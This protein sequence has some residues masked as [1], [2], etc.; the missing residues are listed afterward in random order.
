MGRTLFLYIFK[1]LAK[2]FILAAVALAAI[3]SFGG[4]LRPLT[5]Q[6]LDV[7]QMGWMLTFLMPAMATYSLPIAA[8][9]ACTMVYGRLAA[10]NEMTACRASGIS[11]FVMATPALL[12]GFV[13]AFLSLLFLSFIVPFFTL[14]V[15]RVLYSNIAQLIS[16]KIER[17]HEITF[18]NV[19]IYA[20]DA[21]VI[22]TPGGD[23]NLQIVN[24]TGPTVVTL[25]RTPGDPRLRKPKDFLTAKQA[26][27]FIREN[28]GE[29]ATLEVQLS[30]GIS[31]PREL[32]GGTQVS[33]GQTSFGPVPIPSAIREGTKFMNIT[34][35]KDVLANPLHSRE[36]KAIRDEG[37]RRAQTTAFVT[38][39]L[40]RL[41]SPAKS[42]TF[43]T[44]AQRTTLRTGEMPAIIRG[45]AL[46][47]P[48]D[49]DPAKRPVGFIEIDSPT[50][51]GADERIQQ[52]T[53]REIT[54][55]IRPSTSG[56]SFD[57]SLE[58]RDALID[59][60][61][62][63]VARS[64][65][66]RGFRV[67]MPANVLSISQP[68]VDGDLGRKFQRRLAQLFNEVLAEIHARLSFALSC[69]I[70]VLVGSALGVLFRSGDFLSAFAVSVIPAVLC[71]A[72]IVTGQHT[73]ENIPENL[74]HV[75]ATLRMGLILIYSGN[76]VALVLAVILSLRL[77]RR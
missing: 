45:D 63:R 59:T 30:G 58:L 26:T 33:I 25:D 32:A 9:F 64:V 47:I 62:G 7:G 12:L 69:V 3:M 19:T 51:A 31:F 65:L 43:D 48:F 15:E 44:G 38:S 18:N 4:L 11:Y 60:E 8:L 24:L 29:P 1:D 39:V 54:L 23:D 22:P 50:S 61:G 5:K 67:P 10:D 68:A 49:E 55:R 75:P 13:V 20:D 52:G 71:V 35:L 36:V 57:I 16:N 72:L 40:T 70:L 77:Q 46:V 21:R 6:G 73:A 42:F 27:A 74:E 56:E 41:N 53:A 28:P 34:Q 66:P 14:Q 17:N 37:V 76:A 2:Y